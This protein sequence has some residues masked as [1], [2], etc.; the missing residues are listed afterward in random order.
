MTSW[1]LFYGMF[2][3]ARK[4][5]FSRVGRLKFNI[6]MG[7]PERANLDQQTLSPRDFVDVIT[8]L[9]KLRKGRAIGPDGQEMTYDADD[10]D[11]LGNRRVRAVG[12]LL[13]NQFRLGLVRMERAIKDKMSIHQEMQQAMPRDLVNAKP[14][15]APYGSSLVRHSF[16]SL[17]T[18]RI[19]CRRSPT[20]GGFRRWV[21]ADS[22][23]SGLALRY[24]TCIRPT[25]AASARLKRRKGR[26]SG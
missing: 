26:T 13:E 24:A 22:P 3:D 9:L 8:Y 18:R 14:V 15:M 21:R 19:R 20:S 25:T 10:I 11:H 17:W 12:E 5:D 7:H 23:V 4:F 16:R 6:K 2:F 1:G